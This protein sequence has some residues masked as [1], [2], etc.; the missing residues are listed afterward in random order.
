MSYG[1]EGIGGRRGELRNG[2]EDVGRSRSK[3]S[4]VLADHVIELF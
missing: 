3:A 2:L 1:G 4:E